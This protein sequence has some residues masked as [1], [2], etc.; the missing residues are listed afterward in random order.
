[1]PV[2]KS[3]ADV[4]VGYPG[5]QSVDLGRSIPLHWRDRLDSH[6]EVEQVEPYIISFSLWTGTS[7]YATPGTPET[8]TLIGTRLDPNSSGAVE[9]LRTH[10]DLLVTLGE[11]MTCVVD[12]SEL[13]RIEADFRC[14]KRRLDVTRHLI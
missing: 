7:S 6:P 8:C 2:D 13:G 14:Q 5:V 1:M 9:Y 12:E 3:T 10:P 4:W 11:Q